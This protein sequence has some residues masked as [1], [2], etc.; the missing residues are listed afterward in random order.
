MIMC[1][2]LAFQA[3]SLG[4][5]NIWRRETDSLWCKGTQWRWLSGW[6]ILVNLGISPQPC[7]ISCI[8]F[9]VVNHLRLF[10][11][12]IP[13]LAFPGGLLVGCSP[14]FMNVPKIKGTH[15]AMKS[16][17]LAAECAFEAITDENFSCD[18]Q[19][20]GPKF[21]LFKISKVWLIERWLKIG[22][23]HRMK[24]WLKIKIKNVLL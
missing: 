14:G 24:N 5:A 22:Y 18:T 16:G 2:I 11:Q 6:N 3:S 21:P 15:T 17:M 7:G 10:C 4:K 13:K 19:G 12:C 9:S 20:I 1:C 8:L 23:Y